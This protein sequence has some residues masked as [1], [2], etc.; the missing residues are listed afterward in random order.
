MIFIDSSAWFARYTPRD[1]NHAAAEQ[2]HAETR[3]KLIT[4]DYI[5]DEVLTLL[6]IRGN[7]ERATRV[8][9]A[10]FGGELAQIEWVCKAD[11]EQAWAIFDKYRDKDWSFTDCVSL[12]IM[13]RLGIAKAFAFDEHFRQFGT[14]TVS[15]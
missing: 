2:F 4:S 6:K 15:P 13:K 14:V 3:E 5:I 10:L 11:V 7:V 9:K 1:R 8:G 12:V